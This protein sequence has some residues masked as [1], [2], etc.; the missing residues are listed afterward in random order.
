[1]QCVWC[2]HYISQNQHVSY[3]RR[4]QHELDKVQNVVDGRK[5]TKQA[6]FDGIV[7]QIEDGLQHG[8]GYTLTYVRDKLNISA[9]DCSFNNRELKLLLSIHFGLSITFSKPVEANKPLMFFSSKL[10]IYEVV[11]VVR[12]CNSITECAMLFRDILHQQDYNLHDKFCDAQVL[13]HSWCQGQDHYHL[14]NS[15]V[16]FFILNLAIYNPGPMTVMKKL[17]TMMKNQMVLGT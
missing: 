6:L 8:Y 1:M 13:E 11:E 2:R 3:I 9:V 5:S 4:Y 7:E 15:L 16:R 17:M 10:S 14:Y 12:S